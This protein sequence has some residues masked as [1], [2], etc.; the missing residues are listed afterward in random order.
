LYINV[1]QLL[2]DR[3]VIVQLHQWRRSPQTVHEMQTIMLV[4]PPLSRHDH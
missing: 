3:A 1:A 2:F 4:K